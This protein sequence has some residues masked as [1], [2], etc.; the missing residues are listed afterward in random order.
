MSYLIHKRSQA[1]LAKLSFSTPMGGLDNAN[2]M[3]L[4]IVC[5]SCLILALIVLILCQADMRW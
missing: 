3:H 5:T 4:A 2:L 1:L